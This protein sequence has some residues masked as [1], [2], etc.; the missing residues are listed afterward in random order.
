MPCKAKSPKT[1][2]RCSATA[3]SSCRPAKKSAASELAY[4]AVA[5]KYDRGMV[6]A[7]DLQT[8]A[9][10]LLQARSERLRARLQYII[11]TRLVEYYNGA[12]LIR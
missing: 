7:L 9:N 2:S 3:R 8:A 4:N 11:K 1:T 6:S 10:N 5:G 12:P